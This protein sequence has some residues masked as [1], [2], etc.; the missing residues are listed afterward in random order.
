M[1]TNRSL[2][3]QFLMQ[4]L[5]V[6]K[7]HRKRLKASVEAGTCIIDG[8][9]RPLGSRGLCDNHRQLYYHALRQQ[10]TQEAK[11]AFEREMVSIGNIL[12][13]DVQRKWTTRNPF[14][15]DVS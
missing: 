8:C 12:P 11:I 4:S 10:E 9:D 13:Q 6:P 14:L 1:A 7:T 15:R 3:Q 2:G 5:S